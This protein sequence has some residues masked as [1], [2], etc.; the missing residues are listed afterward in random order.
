MEKMRPP[1]T[2]RLPLYGLWIKIIEQNPGL[3]T[4]LSFV[5]D[6]LAFMFKSNCHQSMC[7]DDAATEFDIQTNRS[8]RFAR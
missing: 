6:T 3:S 4:I 8:K 7:A 2:P 1:I 5:Y